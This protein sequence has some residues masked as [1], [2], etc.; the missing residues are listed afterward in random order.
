MFS[1]CLIYKVHC[2]LSRWVFIV[3]HLPSLVKNFF[4][5]L[6]KFFTMQSSEFPTFRL[7][8]SGILSTAVRHAELLYLTTS[9]PVCQEL[10]HLFQDFLSTSGWFYGHPAVSRKR[11]Y[12]IPRELPFVKRKFL[13]FSNFFTVPVETQKTERTPQC[14]LCF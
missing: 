3:S 11:S 13:F 6:S 4:Q 5:V 8:S 14:P 1:R 7:V 2:P 9:S 10:F 12:I